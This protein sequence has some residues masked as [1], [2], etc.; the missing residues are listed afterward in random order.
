MKRPETAPQPFEPR[1]LEIGKGVVR[2][3]GD[4]LTIISAGLCVAEALKAAD[5]LSGE[6]IDASVVDMASLKPI[7]K[8]L[9][10]ERAKSTGAIVTAEN[11]NIIG[12]LGSAVAE[13]LA[14]AGTG[15]P[16]LRV[17]VR[18]HFCEGGTTPYLMSKFGLDAPA[19]V[20]AARDAVKRKG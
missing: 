15:L 4:S 18:D 2:R 7:D 5:S 13:V 11:H 12:G 16:F 6:G 19:I 3:D 14:E 20:E 8:A 1:S 10:I 17:G 9:I